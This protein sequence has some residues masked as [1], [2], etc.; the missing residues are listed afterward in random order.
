MVFLQPHLSIVEQSPQIL[1]HLFHDQDDGF[2]AILISRYDYLLQLGAK[3]VGFAHLGQM[4]QNS[5]FTVSKLSK[6]WVRGEI[7]D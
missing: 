1:G 7:F 2:E 3:A 6:F 4:S 5:N